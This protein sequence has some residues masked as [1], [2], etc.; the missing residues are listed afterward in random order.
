MFCTAQE[1][2]FKMKRQFTEWEKIFANDMIS[3]GLIFKIY[4]ELTQLNSKKTNKLIKNWAED[5][6]DIFP[7][8]TYRWS[9]GT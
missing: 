1:L 4:K 6:T 7:K 5:L 3:K 8:K 2:T 9:M